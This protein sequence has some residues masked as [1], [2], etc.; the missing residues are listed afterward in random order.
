MT[1]QEF[2]RRCAEMR[3]KYAAAETVRAPTPAV[4]TVRL[5][6]TRYGAARTTESDFQIE[7]TH[8]GVREYNSPLRNGGP[9]RSDLTVAAMSFFGGPRSMMTRNLK[10]RPALLPER[11]RLAS[12]S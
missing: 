7:R 6:A 11:N 2:E 8:P 1:K 9:G 5:A 4:V 10:L 3:A 12:A